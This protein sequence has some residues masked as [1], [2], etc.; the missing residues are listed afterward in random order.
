MKVTLETGH[1]FWLPTPLLMPPFGTI[2]MSLKRHA[3]EI[4]RIHFQASLTVTSD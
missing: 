2:A 4:R 3:I 1:T